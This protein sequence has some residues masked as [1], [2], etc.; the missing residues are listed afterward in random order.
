[1]VSLPGPTAPSMKVGNKMIKNMDSAPKH[2]SIKRGMRESGG[3]DSNMVREKFK[4][5]TVRLS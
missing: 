4:M 3:K 1:M 2:I 5:R